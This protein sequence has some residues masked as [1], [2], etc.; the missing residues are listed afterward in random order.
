[1]C[2]LVGGVQI[3]QEL[4]DEAEIRELA[5]KMVE[6][7]KAKMASMPATQTNRSSNIT[8]NQ[9]QTSILGYFNRSGNKVTPEQLSPDSSD[10]KKEKPAIDEQS[11]KGDN[12]NLVFT[13]F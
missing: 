1:M 12:F 4:P 11:Q 8:T 13:F 9:G 5:A 7:N 3:K 6:A 10:K 2:L